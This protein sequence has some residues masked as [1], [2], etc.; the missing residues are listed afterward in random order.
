MY[1]YK[2]RSRIPNTSIM[3]FNIRSL[4]I[5]IIAANAIQG[6]NQG[7]C[8][9]QLSNTCFLMPQATEGPYYWNATYNRPN[10]T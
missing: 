9:R 6:D 10:V 5:L 3:K 8:K 2:D 7:R 1:I 4:L